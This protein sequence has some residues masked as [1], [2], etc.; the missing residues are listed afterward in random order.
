M[1]RTKGAKDRQKRK[2]AAKLSKAKPPTRSVEPSSWQTERPELSADDFNRAIDAEIA[3]GSTPPGP[4]QDAPAPQAGDTP[5]PVPVFDPSS[6]TIEGLAGAWQVPFWALAWTLKI[7]RVIPDPEPVIA[8]GRR[9][10]KDLAKPS[11]VIYEHYARKYLG[12]NPDNGVH[13]AAGV[14]A[15]NGVGIVPE[16]VEACLKSR[17]QAI[18]AVDPQRGNVPGVPARG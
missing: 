17:R 14:T 4:G 3:T 15:L 7:L 6:L 18:R 5:Q 9:R 10:A 8:V 2:P 11:Y 12:L 1:A 16:I 13:V